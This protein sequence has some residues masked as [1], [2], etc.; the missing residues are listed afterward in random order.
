LDRH[1]SDVL[2][3]TLSERAL[4]TR[5]LRTRPSTATFVLAALALVGCAKHAVVTSSVEPTAPQPLR[6]G[7]QVDKRATVGG[8]FAV[9]LERGTVPLKFGK[10]YA[11]ADYLRVSLSDKEV[12]CGGA[13]ARDDAYAVE[14]DLFPGPALSFFA[15]HPIG[16]EVAVR[17]PGESGSHVAPPYLVDARVEPFRLV[18]GEHLR[19]ALDFKFEWADRTDQA[20]HHAVGAGSFDAQICEIPGEKPTGVPADAGDGALAGTFAGATFTYRTALALV[21]HEDR[22]GADVDFIDVI[23]LYAVDVTCANRRTDAKRTYF[24]VSDISGANSRQRIT[25]HPQ[26]AVARFVT[27]ANGFS[28]SQQFGR[29]GAWVR[30]DTLAFEQG[31]SVTGAALAASA[32]PEAALTGHVGGRFEA[33]V[34][35]E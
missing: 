20:Q 7:V 31:R 12:S 23:E 28:N 33:T 34:C 27:P 22:Q 16:I 1:G 32:G 13:R 10:A 9:N 11:T 8:A 35:R 25:G 2:F 5:T 17:P 4:S 18:A 19:G 26:P 29:P 21:R 3:V 24:S 15:G 30:L 6:G 14:L